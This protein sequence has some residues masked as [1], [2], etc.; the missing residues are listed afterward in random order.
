MS[1]YELRKNAIETLFTV[2]TNIKHICVTVYNSLS[3]SRRNVTNIT[4]NFNNY[5]KICKE[6]L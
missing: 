3:A 1:I 5:F 4:D 2:K 6:S